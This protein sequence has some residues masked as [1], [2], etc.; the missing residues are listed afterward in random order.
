M[1]AEFEQLA[2]DGVEPGALLK[3]LN[4]FIAQDFDG[5]GMYLSAF[6]GLLNFENGK[7]LYS[8]YG[9]PPQYVYR[10]TKREV[11]KLS[12]QSTFLGIVDRDEKIYQNQ[13]DFSRED[14]IF[15]FTDGVIEAEN[16]NKEQYGAN[17]VEV[18]LKQHYQLPGSEFHQ[19]L[20]AELKAY[21]N[22]HF[23]DDVFL[24]SIKVH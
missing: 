21:T 10:G 17:R 1:H 19:M 9:H 13:V 7:L 16:A 6:C 23:R 18:F 11:L 4:Q 15:L 3:A 8:N 24:L 14:R 20:I 12:A 5:T 22:N 2:K